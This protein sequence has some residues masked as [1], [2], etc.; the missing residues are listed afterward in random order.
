MLVEREFFAGLGG[1]DPRYFLYSEDID[2]SRRAR[3]RGARPLVDPDAM[4]IHVGG[5]SSSSVGQRVKILRGR[6]TYLRRHFS[7][8]RARLGRALLATG[9]ALRAFAAKAGAGGRGT[10]WPAIWRERRTWLAGWPPIDEPRPAPTT[11]V[12]GRAR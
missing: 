2:L 3:D 10:D 4:V 12:A 8:A 7:P 6:T 11:E 1:F 9:V 5:A